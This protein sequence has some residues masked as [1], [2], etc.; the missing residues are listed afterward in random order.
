M[1]RYVIKLVPWETRIEDEAKKAFGII[2]YA[3]NVETEESRSMRPDAQDKGNTDLY[4]T[5]PELVQLI[6]KTP[7]RN[8]RRQH[9][10]SSYPNLRRLQQLRFGPSKLMRFDK[11]FGRPLL[12]NNGFHHNYEY[13]HQPLGRLYSLATKTNQIMT[14]GQYFISFEI[15]NALQCPNLSY[16]IGVMRPLQEHDWQGMPESLWTQFNVF[17]RSTI[18]YLNKARTPSWTNNIDCCVISPR[19]LEH[20]LHPYDRARI[21]RIS[22]K[23][24]HYGDNTYNQI[25]RLPANESFIKADVK[26]DE[27]CGLLLNMDQGTLTYYINGKSTQLIAENLTGPYVWMIQFVGFKSCKTDVSFR[28]FTY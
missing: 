26:G 23:E 14:E 7:I 22:W 10:V 24:E 25:H 4:D 3:Y 19:Q 27:R 21:R 28:C 13:T 15:L 1:L 6:T 18:Q 2:Q 17:K 11:F 5:P 12:A 9:H 8:R 16:D 20:I